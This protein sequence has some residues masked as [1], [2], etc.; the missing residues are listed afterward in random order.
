MQVSYNLLKEYVDIDEVSPEEL[1]Q[2]LTISGIVLEQ[3]ENISI[4]VEKIVVGKII[5][6]NLHPENSNLSVCQ[7]DVKDKI[8]QIVCGARNMKVFDKVAVALDGAKLPQIG[9]IKSKKIGNILSSGMLCSAS[10]LG[11]E[12]GKSPGIL[13]LDENY[14]LG[15]DIRKLINFDDTIFD[16]E[17][18]SNRPDLLSIIGIAREVAV[19]FNKRLKIPEIEIKESEERIEKNISVKVEAEDLCPRYTGR[20][21][22]GVKIE[23]SPLWLKWK[24][25]LLGVRPI[26]NI[27][28]ITNFVMM[29]T[30]QPLHAFDLDLIRGK[31]II[32]RKSK[33]GEIICTLDDVERQLP[34]GSLV[35]A[36]IESPI[37]IGGI[38]GGKYSEINLDTKNVFLESAYFNAVNNRKTTIKLGLRTEAS[39]RFEKNIDK[40]GQIF[41]LERAADL[42]SR[43]ALG[44]ISS[45]TIDTNPKLFTPV[46]INLRVERVNRILGQYLE[47][48]KLKTKKRIV[49]ILTQL[50]FDIKGD[51]GE[52]IEVISP[53]FRGDVEREIDLIEEIARIYGY[54][55]IKPTLFKTTIAQKGKSFRL[56]LIDQIREILIGC[57][58]NEVVTY[59]FISPEI[60]DKIR[61]PKGHKLRNAVKIKDPLT[62]DCSLMRT[63]LIPSLLEVIKWNINRQAEIVKIFEVGKIYLPYPGKL[64]S[65]PLEKIIIGGAITKLGRGDIWT[66]SFSLDIFD[67]KGLIETILQD[68]NVK[69]WEVLPVNHP[70]LHPFRSGR[71]VVKGKEVGIFGE[72]HPDVINN[73]RIPEKVN[74][75]EIDFENLV[76]HVPTSISYRALP[77]YPSVQRDLS[78]VVREEVLSSEI[79]KE[80]NSVNSKLIKKIILFDIF[81][82]K[83]IGEG[84]KSL[85]YSVIFQSEKHTL[86][87][88][89]VEN[90]F[91]KIKEKLIVKFNA[92]IRE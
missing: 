27:V 52:H 5:D 51:Y 81:K 25:R 21:V 59:S 2:R 85:A 31:T 55:Q 40:A 87:D 63:S 48:D 13:I 28:D 17:I 79:I 73:Y 37:A 34:E 91:K 41:A 10:E 39:N 71:I 19:I 92:K 22:K 49:N 62:K 89:E 75:F 20:V 53:S 12:Q 66:K 90:I 67:V 84:Y 77:K 24:L 80:I 60:F 1:A 29:E 7:V 72:I 47:K 42:I 38:M 56:R 50:G 18:N 11:I 76:S 86:T 9:I 45:G 58:L 35:I 64:N 83:Q 16:F 26:N 6:I 8:L 70:S 36:D 88:Q 30:G 54:D 82:G 23:E 33:P 32:V 69:N 43:I 44:K 14:P 74:L 61:I 4:D 65:L 57:G 15:E 78:L 46:K 3:M 68:L